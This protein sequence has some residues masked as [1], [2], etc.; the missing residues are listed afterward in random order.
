MAELLYTLEIYDDYTAALVPHKA[1][2][3]RGTLALAHT[4]LA[5]KCETEVDEQ[6]SHDGGF[7]RHY[8]TGWHSISLRGYAADRDDTP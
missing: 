5:L 6:R 2:A 8:R 3:F 4:R 1:D 7:V